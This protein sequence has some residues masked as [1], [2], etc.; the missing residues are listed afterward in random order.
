MQ[1][2][3][4]G[5]AL[6]DV[7]CREIVRLRLCST[8][9]RTSPRSSTAVDTGRPLL[10]RSRCS[11]SSEWMLIAALSAI[12]RLCQ[13]PHAGPTPAYQSTLSEY[14][15][16]TASGGG[17]VILATLGGFC[18]YLRKKAGRSAAKLGITD[19]TQKSR[20]NFA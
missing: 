4:E 16:P 6:L 19:C 2:D 3:G 10:R 7:P 15:E 11:I 14:H 13:R 9:R 18:M 12:S 8:L 1:G 17:G 20:C 5:A